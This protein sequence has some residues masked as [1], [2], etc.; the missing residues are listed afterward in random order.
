MSAANGPYWKRN[1]RLHVAKTIAIFLGFLLYAKIV[2]G[3][4]YTFVCVC[5]YGCTTWIVVCPKLWFSSGFAS[6]NSF[7]IVNQVATQCSTQLFYYIQLFKGLGSVW[8]I[9]YKIKNFIKQEGI[10][11][12]KS[13]SKDF[14][15]VI[16]KQTNKQTN[17][18]NSNRCHSFAVY[19]EKCP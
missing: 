7:F 13:D 5:V 9:L 16:N 18:H 19:K 15:N 1:N 3:S 14:Y 12:T 8:H 4:F 17:N 11:L 10:T 6:G 2:G